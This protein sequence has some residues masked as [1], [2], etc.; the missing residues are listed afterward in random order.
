M[1]PKVCLITFS[2]LVSDGRS[3]NALRAISSVSNVVCF[4]LTSDKEFQELL[5]PKS[6]KHFPVIVPKKRLLLNWHFFIN[7]VKDIFSSFNQFG[8]YIFWACDLYSLGAVYKIAR[9]SDYVIYDSRE[10][11]SALA[12]LSKSPIKQKILT[13]LEKKWVNIVN[14]FVVSG[15]LDAEYLKEYFK[16]QKMFTTIYNVPPYKEY[17]ETNIIK[18][19]YPFLK[20]YVILLYQGA[21]HYGRGISPVLDFI[22]SSKKYA[23][24]VLGNGI[25]L[26]EA[27]IIA[28]NKGI[29]DRVVFAGNIPYE[30]LHQWTCSADIG[31]NLIEPISLSYK[32]A[33]PNKLFEY[34]MAGLPQ[35]VSSLPA[36][37]K[38]INQYHIGVIVNDFTPNS[39]LNAI[40]KIIDN[41][42]YYRQNCLKFAKNNNYDIEEQK[43]QKIMQII[44]NN[45]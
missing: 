42:K 21:V 13:F 34:A 22:A 2:N 9:K 39:I 27:K 41:Y 15:E 44:M 4:S 32:F 8:K 23:F 18:E 16:T 30:D 3:L 35:V 5:L 40:E 36:L 25:F 1:Q 19:R 6:V 29:L 17:V 37:E 7:Y 20:D 10:I 26:N 11:Y 45:I 14:H 33:L 28:Q 24:V 43:I 31:M 38:I 12:N